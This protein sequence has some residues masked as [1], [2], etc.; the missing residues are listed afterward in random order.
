MFFILTV[1]SCKVLDDKKTTLASWSQTPTFVCLQAAKGSLSYAAYALS[2]LDHLKR[3]STWNV[4]GPPLKPQPNRQIN[5]TNAGN[6]SMIYLSELYLELAETCLPLRKAN[7]TPISTFCLPRYC[8]TC[9]NV[10]TWGFWDCSVPVLNC[11]FHWFSRNL[12]H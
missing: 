11:H 3:F 1:C 7:F 10:A 9:T 5:P 2:T 8:L 12:F 4:H 6:V